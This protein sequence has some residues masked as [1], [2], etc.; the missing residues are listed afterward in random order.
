MYLAMVTCCIPISGM[1][2]NSMGCNSPPTRM[3][4]VWWRI[5]LTTWTSMMTGQFMEEKFV[6]TPGLQT[7][8][9]QRKVTI[10]G[11]L[12][13]LPRSSLHVVRME[14]IRT[15]VVPARRISTETAVEVTILLDVGGLL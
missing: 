9:T 12:L 5:S 8:H 1:I 2:Q 15:D 13:V 6:S 3:W 14:A 7:T 4:A 11:L 10:P